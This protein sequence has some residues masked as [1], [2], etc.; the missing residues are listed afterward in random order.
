MDTNSNQLEEL[1]KDS[2]TVYEIILNS[3]SNRLKY[4]SSHRYYKSGNN[5]DCIDDKNTF[6]MVHQSQIE[7]QEWILIPVDKENNIFEIEFFTDEYN[8]KGWKLYV[9]IEKQDQLEYKVTLS[10]NNASKW[11]LIPIGEN[12]EIQEVTT[13]YNLTSHHE[14]LVRDSGSNFVYVTN[15]GMSGDVWKITLYTRKK[16]QPHDL[17]SKLNYFK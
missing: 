13:E 7:A 3:N 11:K 8:Q 5:N 1:K 16:V 15:P 12:F 6:I 10:K 14:T 17:I 4:L 2:K 9:P